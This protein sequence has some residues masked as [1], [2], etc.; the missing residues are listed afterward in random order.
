MEKKHHQSHSTHW[1]LQCI[2]IIFLNGR[3]QREYNHTFGSYNAFSKASL[4]PILMDETSIKEILP[5]RSYSAS[6][7]PIFKEE[8]NLNGILPVGTYRCNL[9]TV[10]MEDVNT[11]CSLLIESVKS[12]LVI[13]VIGKSEF[14]VVGK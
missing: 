8:T 5:V 13:Y 6:T 7:S 12:V 14:I 3:N 9:S 4:S 2:F 1:K 10:I 11:V